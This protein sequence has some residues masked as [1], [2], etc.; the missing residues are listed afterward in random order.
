MAF[1]TLLA[2]CWAL[3]R[4]FGAPFETPIANF[5]EVVLARDPVL[6]GL[7]K[8]E[9]RFFAGW[10][11]GRAE[12][13]NEHLVAPRETGVVL[14]VRAV[15]RQ[16]PTPQNDLNMIGVGATLATTTSSPT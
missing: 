11:L 16:V 10:C 8:H 3:Q 15:R 14:I 2:P 13:A 12:D 6:E 7:G 1:A 4:L 5:G 9:L